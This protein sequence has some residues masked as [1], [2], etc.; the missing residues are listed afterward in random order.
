MLKENCT[1]LHDCR[2]ALLRCS[3]TDLNRKSCWR[4][5]SGV[6][7]AP[8]FGQ[9]KSGKR[10][11]RWAKRKLQGIALLSMGFAAV[12]SN[13]PKP[14]ITL[15]IVPTRCWDGALFASLFRQAKSKKKI[16]IFI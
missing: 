15:A 8:L 12:L 9:A 4:L 13:G 2:W 10:N 5:I 11:N 7:F 3:I 1:A 16:S 14:E 6:F